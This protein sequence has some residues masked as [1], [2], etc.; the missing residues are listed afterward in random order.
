VEHPKR[1]AIR[2]VFVPYA[3]LVGVKP[4][5]L[6]TSWQQANLSGL[7]ESFILSVPKARANGI[8]LGDASVDPVKNNGLEILPGVPIQLSINNERQVY[9]VQSP[10]ADAFCAVPESIPV[11][12]W[13]PATIYL[14]AIAPTSIG[15]I[16]FPKPYV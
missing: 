13:D 5:P 4:T 12:V 9:E 6:N 11:I 14:V 8:F 7:Y 10:I 1:P 3:L 2:Q 15:V 16:L